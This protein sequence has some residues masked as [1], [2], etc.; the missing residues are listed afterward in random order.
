M[1]V[2]HIMGGHASG[3]STLA[4]KFINLPDTVVLGK[5]SKSKTFDGMTGGMDMLKATQEER[6]NLIK[7][8][9]LGDKK[10]VILEGMMC[11]YNKSF[12]SRYK[13]LQA[14]KKRKVYAILL[15]SKTDK[16]IERISKRSKGKVFDEKR[17]RH[18]NSKARG[19]RKNYNKLNP[20]EYEKLEFDT[21]DENNFLAIEKRLLEI[22]QK[23]EI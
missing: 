9:W 18:I 15:E 12:F 17:S 7:K 11:I 8:E 6:F 23:E 1:V 2:L 22:L 20:M 13:E 10:N 3:K 19:A 4:G 21:T 5:Y 14:I 16:V